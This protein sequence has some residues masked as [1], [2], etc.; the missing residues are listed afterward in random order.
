MDC[1]GTNIYDEEFDAR[2]A[3][4]DLRDYRANGPTAWTARLIAGLTGV[5]VDGMTVLDIGGGV[6]AVHHALLASGARAATDVDASGHYLA[7]ARG[8]AERRGLADRVTFM[9][10][11]A[12]RLARDL[13][14][15][16]L[17]ALDR[18]VCC[19]PNME[20]LVGVAA[21]RTRR[22][23]GIVLPRDTRWVRAAV[24][25]RNGWSALTRDPFRVYA[26][27]TASLLAV[28]E[29]AGLTLVSS[30][31]GLFWES[32]ILERAAV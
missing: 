23:L 5:G 16:D 12:V 2:Q 29:T 30:H 9:R 7:A 10:G 18:V 15:A 3:E 25:L 21:T 6:G 8:E 17:V 31:R 19:Y 20:A 13:P 24:A 28:A 26:H 4:R 22:R 11:D 14:A 32:L 27:R 1:C